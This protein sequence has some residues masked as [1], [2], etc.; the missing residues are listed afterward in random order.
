MI[1]KSIVTLTAMI[2][3]ALLLAAGAN[4]ETLAY[5]DAVAAV[6]RQADQWR[7]EH[8]IIDLHEHM[9]YSSET[10]GRAL[11]VLDAS[12]AGLPVDLTPGTV[13]P[14][15]NGEPGKFERNKKTEDTLFPGRWQQYMNLDV[16]RHPGPTFVWRA[17]RQQRG[18]VGVGRPATGP[19][20]QHDG[21]SG[22]PHSGN[23]AA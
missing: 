15:P 9:D 21:R 6:V 4:A 12:G 19:T 14:G 1:T 3:A 13:T 2:C 16:G 7:A 22:G 17:F 23:R 11:R 5:Q 20:P 8:R 10:L 18:G